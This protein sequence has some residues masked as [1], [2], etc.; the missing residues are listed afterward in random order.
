MALLQVNNVEVKYFGVILVLRGVSLEL[1]SRGLVALLGSNGAGKTTMLKAI[2]GLL[3]TDEGKVSR[4]TIEY[5]EEQIQNSNPE[6][7]ARK[8]IIQVLEGRQIVEHLTVDENLKAGG[9]ILGSRS[10]VKN[11]LEKVYNHFPRLAELR[12][13]VSGYLSGGEQQM[14]VVG[15]GLMARPKVMLIDEASL[16]L[17]PILQKEIYEI[18]QRLNEDDGISILMVEQN[19]RAA[20]E[21]AHYAYI[22]ENGRIVLEGPA[23][24]LAD[25]EDI[26]EFYV[27][28][29][30]TGQM[31]SYREVKH[32][33]RR[34][35]WLS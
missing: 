16:G 7:I 12:H 19:V 3:K 23:A 13:Q 27:G 31:K 5:E 35:R 22:M 28:V 2:S 33:K 26:K 17:A 11:R 6:D 14:L 21:I 25:N 20:L 10:A 32:Y 34:K 30:A 24:Q 8:G 1:E 18:I 4:G 29:G 15:R 9:Y